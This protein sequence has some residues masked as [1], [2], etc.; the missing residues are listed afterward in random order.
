MISVRKSDPVIFCENCNKYIKGKGNWIRHLNGISHKR[1]LNNEKISNNFIC[2][3][4][5]S[6]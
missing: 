2:S 6:L 5:D 1:N 4:T 3:S